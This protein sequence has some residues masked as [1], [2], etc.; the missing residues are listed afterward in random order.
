[1]ARAVCQYLREIQ[2]GA[3]PWVLTGR[4][5]DTGP[6]NEPLLVNIQPIA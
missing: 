5:A 6:D 4:V 2:E 1:V 3:C